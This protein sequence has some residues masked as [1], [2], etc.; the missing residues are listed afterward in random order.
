VQSEKI[1]RLKWFL[2]F[3]YLELGN[4]EPR[5]LDKINAELNNN[6]IDGI[7]WFPEDP[8]EGKREI[9][10]YL[11]LYEDAPLVEKLK[12]FQ[13]QIKDIFIPFLN[14]ESLDI[15]EINLR[16]APPTPRHIAQDKIS[17]MCWSTTKENDFVL[18][19][20]RA[21]AGASFD[22][23]Q[24]CPEC[25][26]WFIHIN[27]RK[28]IYCSNNCAARV[29]ARNRRIKMREK[30]PLKY[31][32]ELRKGAK[33]ARKTYEKN[34]KKNTPNAKITRKPYKYITEED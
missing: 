32:E 2:D 33:R 17:V 7:K 14:G 6:Y 28:K 16:I 11:D 21:L 22:I 13:A 15:I 10:A 34:I 20:Y 19:L 9:K 23:F 27:K 29:G 18:H 5:D 30:N 31:E 4:L 8:E 12:K 24:K 26:R 3:C 1:E 25:D